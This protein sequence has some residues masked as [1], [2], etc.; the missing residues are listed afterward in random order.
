MHE[1][2]NNDHLNT[3]LTQFIVMDEMHYFKSEV[4]NSGEFDPQID[5]Q[6][7]PLFL[8]FYFHYN[9]M[10]NHTFFKEML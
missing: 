4:Y 10:K 2:N 7:T 5:A 1:W 8:L 6:Q 3:F 9:Y